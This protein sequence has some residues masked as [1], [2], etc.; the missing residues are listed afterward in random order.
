MMKKISKCWIQ[1]SNKSHLEH[2]R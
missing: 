1:S 2:S